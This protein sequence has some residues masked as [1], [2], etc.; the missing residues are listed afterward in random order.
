M[1]K[2]ARLMFAAP[3]S[4]SGKTTV[5]LAFL[6]AL[7]HRGLSPAA[8]KCG[9]DYIDPLFHRE[10]VGVPGYN[11]DLFFTEGE[12]VRGLLLKGA[13]GRDVAVVEGVMGYYDGAGMEGAASSWH[14]AKQTETPA[15]LVVTPGGASLSVAALVSGF[16]RFREES[17]LRGVVLNRCSHKQYQQL[18][19]AIETET[20]LR[21][22]GYL[23][24][25]PQAVL[26][27]RHLGL[28]IPT[29]T[30]QLREKLKL[31]GEAALGTLDID[32]LLALADGAL[33]LKAAL[34]E[35]RP[36]TGETVAIAVARDDAFCFYYQENLEMLE[37]L[38]A[39]LL[40]FSPLR[41]KT[42]PKE[43]A[44]LYIGG[45]YP[46]LMAR[47]LSG[48]TAMR[49]AIAHAVESG[50]P[51]VAECGGFMYLQEAICD[52]EGISWPMVGALPG[53][54]RD[55][56]GLSRF[57]YIHL[58]SAHAGMSGPRGTVMRGHEFHRWD[59]TE[60]GTA[61]LAEKPYDT[62]EWQCI[63]SGASLLAGYPHLYFWS[64]PEVAR[65]FVAVAA[66]YRDKEG[67]IHGLVK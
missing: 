65:R 41:D 32:G 43:A 62:R 58:T 12:L 66:E 42:L 46:E 44:G 59:S 3:G 33:P 18:A 22:Y 37:A 61:F 55:S 63:Q 1:D 28:V 56:G 35:L 23:P 64:N 20:G 39:Q 38:G 4:G 52:R 67:V 57:G 54:S 13:G 45:G 36:A 49:S 10:V 17:M 34:P 26:E 31:L 51:T 6:Q 40:F 5:T 14:L 29:E 50:L 9:P 60:T 7:L 11:L 24:S 16:A 21:V 19:P 2:L 47:E 27:H 53:A 8:F 48:N 15:V 30:E 25:V